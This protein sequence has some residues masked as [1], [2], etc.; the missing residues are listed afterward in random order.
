MLKSNA[1]NK[2]AKIPTKPIILN[3]LLR[4]LKAVVVKTMIKR[5]TAVLEEIKKIV[6]IIKNTI[7]KEALLSFVVLNLN[8]LS[9]QKI[10]DMTQ[11]NPR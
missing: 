9:R 3:F 2:S 10:V 5:M 7:N 4:V 8:M 11:K 6:V 1:V